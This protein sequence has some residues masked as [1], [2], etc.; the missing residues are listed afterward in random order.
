[1]RIDCH[2]HSE[3]SPD[4]LSGLE[5]LLSRAKEIGLGKLIITDHNTI[6]GAVKLQQSYPESVIVGEEIQTTGGEILALFVREEIPAYLEPLEAFRRL[7]DQDAFISLSHPYAFSRMGWKEEEMLRYKP[8]L[9]AIE[10]ANGRNTPGMNHKAS[11][12]AKAN[13]LAGTAGSDGHAV[14]ELG[15][16]GLELPEFTT[17]NELRMA[18]REAKIFGKESSLFV[19]YYSRKAVLVKEFRKNS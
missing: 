5:E 4:S 1:M 19:R 8:F 3:Y 10:T 6:A 17:A 18:V 13:G 9:D 16:I 14:R 12:F 7:R 15:R 11:E 2:L